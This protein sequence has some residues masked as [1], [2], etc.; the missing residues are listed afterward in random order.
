[1]LR[2]RASSSSAPAICVHQFTRWSLNTPLWSW[3]RI[4]GVKQVH[5]EYISLWKDVP[6]RLVDWPD[7]FF[8]EGLDPSTRLFVLQNH[9]G[10]F[11]FPHQGIDELGKGKKPWHSRADRALP[12]HYRA[13]PCHYHALPCHYRALPCHYRAIT[14]H[15]R[16]ITVPLL[17]HYRALPCHYHVSRLR[18]LVH[19]SKYYIKNR[20]Y[21]VLFVYLI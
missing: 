13:L 12:C 14:V 17:C 3:W 21:H 18:V 2:K 1:M 9:L 4:S 11:L 7:P 15:Y 8:V 6:K 20:K 16:A 19:V 10:A 5:I